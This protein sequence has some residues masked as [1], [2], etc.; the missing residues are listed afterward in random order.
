MP[1]DYWLAVNELSFKEKPVVLS[2][3]P[4]TRNVIMGTHTWNAAGNN[5][6][7]C[8]VGKKKR[9]KTSSTS[10]IDCL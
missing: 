7:G 10:I 4:L 3:L 5:F 6:Q 2:V 9:K 1:P 8:T